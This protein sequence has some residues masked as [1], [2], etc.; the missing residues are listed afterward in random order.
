MLRINQIRLAL[1]YSKN[2]LEDYIIKCL[3]ISQKDLINYKIIKRSVDARDKSKIKY[4]LSIDVS[5]IDE[6]SV[7]K[8]FKKSGFIRNVSERKY[9]YIAK[10]SNQFPRLEE[11]R[12]VI[13]GAGPCGYFAA[14]ILAQ[15]GF[16]PLLLERGESV[17]DRSIQAYGFWSRR[18]KLSVDS[19]VQFGEGGAGTFSDG[20]LY[21]QITDPDN[22]RRKVLEE[23]VQSGAS[24]DILIN[25]RPHIGTYK[26]AAIVRKFRSRIEDLG[27]EIRF[28]AKMEELVLKKRLTK[29]FNDKDFEVEGIKLADGS[30]LK[31]KYLILALGH[32]ARDS[33]RML[34]R[35]GVYLEQKLFAVGFRIEHLQCKVDQERWGEMSGH[36][37]LGRAEYKLV[38]HSRNGRNVYSFCMC[39]G[40]QVVGAASDEECVVTN[41]MSQHTRNE[42]NAN[43]ALVVN[44]EKEDLIEFERW[45]GD[46]LAGVAFQEQLERK[47]FKMGGENYFAPIQRLDDFINSVVSVRIG[48]IKPSYLPGVHFADLNNSLPKQFI[49]SIKESL[50]YFAKKNSFF[51][52]PDAILTGLETRTSSPIRI[53]RDVDLESL[54]VF[55]L[56]PAGEGAGYAGGIMS[57]GIDGIKAAEAMARKILSSSSY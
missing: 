42:K 6:K 54:N 17:K 31:T 24:E 21:S 2:D 4:V 52:E 7:L 45:P 26:L 14:L 19:N 3:H 53:T 33:F 51:M 49:S 28:G 44:L 35:V 22:Y 36:P 11:D 48:S 16:K 41:G 13:V 25:N 29:K 47:A 37:S 43:S 20:K 10:A 57:A 40:G 56:I 50:P 32:S 18:C 12:P 55:G 8:R 5:L 23:F 39:P 1:D 38:Y 15:M 46:P 30:F 27:G 34:D 9:K